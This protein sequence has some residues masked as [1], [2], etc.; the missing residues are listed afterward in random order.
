MLNYDILNYLR[1]FV[2]DRRIITLC[3][4]C[5][6]YNAFI[7]TMQQL[8]FRVDL[9]KIMNVPMNKWTSVSKWIT[10][11]NTSDHIDQEEYTWCQDL[12]LILRGSMINCSLN[13]NLQHLDIHFGATDMNMNIMG[14]LT[15]LKSFC[16]RNNNVKRH[17]L[18]RMGDF[19]IC[20]PF[21]SGSIIIS[22]PVSLTSLSIHDKRLTKHQLSLSEFMNLKRLE[23]KCCVKAFT[24]PS[25]LKY[26]CIENNIIPNL[27]HCSNLRSLILP[28]YNAPFDY[29][30]P[31]SLITLNLKSYNVPW[32]FSLPSSLK[33]LI[34]DQYQSP[35]ALPATLIHLHHI[36]KIDDIPN[37][38]RIFKSKN[39]EYE[40]KNLIKLKTPNSMV[41]NE[42]HCHLIH[43]DCI[44]IENIRIMPSNLISLR[45]HLWLKTFN[46]LCN[47][48]RLHVNVIDK[49]IDFTLLP[50]LRMMSIGTV[51]H[52]IHFTSSHIKI[53]KIHV[54]RY[55]II[56][57]DTLQTLKI[58]D[59][60]VLPQW[61][62]HLKVLK[63]NY[64]NE[65]F[66]QTWPG[67]LKKLYLPCY[68]QSF[69]IPFSRCLRILH[70]KLL[71]CP[72]HIDVN[73]ILEIIE[74]AN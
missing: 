15:Q 74:Y 45:V 24:L 46:M 16:L 37:T 25:S 53:L 55:M 26:V 50:H 71:I 65:K 33:K 4:T 31:A 61:P 10:Y 34:I 7:N 19:G 12:K 39:S 13:A 29:A 63:L 30:L 72:H 20:R 32:T 68:C 48:T 44:F 27:S 3:R 11:A 40:S 41:L 42:N 66:N 35:Y 56:L 1:T 9:N 22:L 51:H 18:F 62:T 58:K 38:L 69:D 57:N 21:Q 2:N 36:A 49:Q 17:F 67:T 52:S 64:Y 28:H 43:L 60:N 59:I 5:K 70:V 54:C 14:S 47:L 8:D 73:H 23:L 6:F